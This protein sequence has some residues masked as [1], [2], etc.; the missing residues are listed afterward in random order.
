MCRRAETE[1]GAGDAVSGPAGSGQDR[2]P[3]LQVPRQT[4][5]WLALVWEQGAQRDVPV[6]VVTPG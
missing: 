5:Q 1:S 4:S 2:S 3:P 6:P